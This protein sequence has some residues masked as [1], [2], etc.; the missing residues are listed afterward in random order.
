MIPDT[1]ISSFASSPLTEDIFIVK[2]SVFSKILQFQGCAGDGDGISVP[3]TI[4]ITC[5]VTNDS[6]V[7]LFNI[8]GNWLNNE[9]GRLELFMD[10]S[11]TEALPDVLPVV[12]RKTFIRVGRFYVKLV[13]T[14]NTNRDLIFLIGDCHIAQVVQATP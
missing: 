14:I 7:V 10:A 12:A 8:P 6:G 3:D 9:E 2:G 11:E 1:L 5:E 4:S 13:D